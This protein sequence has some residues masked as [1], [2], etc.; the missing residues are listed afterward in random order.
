MKSRAALPS[1]PWV[2]AAA[3]SEDQRLASRDHQS[4]SPNSPFG[5][6]RAPSSLPLSRLR[7]HCGDGAGSTPCGWDR[8]DPP[9]HRGMGSES[10]KRQDGRPDRIVIFARHLAAFPGTARKASLAQGSHFE[11]RTVSFPDKH[12]DASTRPQEMAA[13]AG[14]QELDVYVHLPP[15]PPRGTQAQAHTGR[16]L[17]GLEPKVCRS[18]HVQAHTFCADCSDTCS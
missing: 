13:R 12:R 14:A 9:A 16:P 8:P 7:L 11:V 5:S 17:A 15:T 4:S 3:S 10:P 2:L 1:C 18:A 6:L